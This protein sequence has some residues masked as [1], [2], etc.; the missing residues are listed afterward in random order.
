M[1][2]KA[3][4][5]IF[6]V[7]HICEKRGPGHIVI[8]HEGPKPIVACHIDTQNLNWTLNPTTKSEVCSN[9]LRNIK[10]GGA[11]SSISGDTMQEEQNTFDISGLDKEL[12]A[13]LNNG[14]K[15]YLGRELKTVNNLLRWHPEPWPE[16]EAWRDAE[17]RIHD[18][19]DKVDMIDMVGVG[20]VARLRVIELIKS[21]LD[22]QR[23][24]DM[25]KED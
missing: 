15:A 25:E 23:I 8:G 17:Q 10:K 19:I 21:A 4:G 13:R 9:C 6:F 14:V 22:D 11:Y 24:S 12:R 16:M 5:Y 1:T 18:E 2:H 3:M 20:T 7:N